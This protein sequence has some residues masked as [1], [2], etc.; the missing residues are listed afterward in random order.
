MQYIHYENSHAYDLTYD[1]RAVYTADF[2]FQLGKIL[3]RA[4]KVKYI[5]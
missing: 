3:N 2:F 1:I 5:I 4:S